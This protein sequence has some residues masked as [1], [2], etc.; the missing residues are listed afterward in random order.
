MQLEIDRIL[1]SSNYTPMFL[2]FWPVVSES[3]QKIFDL[4]VTLILVHPK[5]MSLK[6]L[7]KLSEFGEIQLLQQLPKIPSANQAKLARWYFACQQNERIVSVE[8][9]D[10]IYL[11]NQYLIEKLSEFEN[12]KL[13]GIGS[14]VYE[15]Q[16]SL[17]SFPASN[18]TG[19]GVLF[20][21]LFGYKKG[22]SFYDFVCQYQ[23]MK[24]FDTREDPFN[25][26]KHFSDESLIRAL[27]KVNLFD[28]IKVIP[29]NIDEK[30]HWLDRSSWPNESKI[31]VQKYTTV[32]FLRPL[33]EN[34]EKCKPV[35]DIFFPQ[36]YPWVI[37]SRTP[38]HK[39][40]DHD[41]Y[42]LPIYVKHILKQFMIK[43]KLF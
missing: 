17:N 11:K 10:T 16:F 32:N 7:N 2:N 40:F 25:L 13:L 20:S 30:E 6:V 28:K 27:R 19:S 24:I 9:I 8:D 18:L 23:G 42:K 43:C 1:V 36:G 39:N 22:M 21:K 5:K 3:W 34:Y 29:R 26:P 37:R 41:I 15:Q 35:L 38:I 4:N 31:E 14:E 33:F 12:G